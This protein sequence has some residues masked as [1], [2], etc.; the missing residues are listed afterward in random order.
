MLN[1]SFSYTPHLIC[2][3]ILLVVSSKYTQNINIST[4][5]TSPSHHH[6]SPTYYNNRCPCF[7][8]WHPILFSKHKSQLLCHCFHSKFFNGFLSLSQWERPYNGLLG[9]II[10]AP[11]LPLWT[12]LFMTLFPI[13]M[14]S[15]LASLLFPSEQTNRTR[16]SNQTNVNQK[17][18]P[19]LL[20]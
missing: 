2:Q 14:F 17:S 19:A 10:S 9:T 12:H 5:S 16:L 1:S 4:T 18:Y 13:I 3:K 8:P 6:L 20:Y 11:H 15:T 7:C